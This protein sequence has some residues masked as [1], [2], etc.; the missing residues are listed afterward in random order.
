MPADVQIKAP[1]KLCWKCHGSGKFFSGGMV[2]N[3]RYTGTVGKCFPCGGKGQ[4]T[5]ADVRRTEYY[6]AHIYRAA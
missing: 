5:P 1:N 2:L 6:F 4:Q 3:G